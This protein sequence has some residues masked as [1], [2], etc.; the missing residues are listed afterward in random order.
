MNSSKK[1]DF[2]KNSICY[3][4]ANAVIVLAAIVVISIWGFNYQTSVTG[5]KLLLSS[6]LSIIISLLLVF[7]YVGLRYDF[8]KA[9]SIVLTV[10]HNALLSTALI[11]IIRV[12]VTE[13]IVMGYILLVGLSTA[14]TLILTEK[15]KDVNLKKVDYNEIIK[16]TMASSIKQ[17]VILSAVVV[18]VL[19]LCLITL[20][21]NM[22]N[23]IRILLV[24]VFVLIYSSLTIILPSW[25]YFSSKIK[26]VKKAK[27][28]NNVENQKVVKAAVI[29]GEEVGSATINN[30]ETEE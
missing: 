22:F 19:L 17:I 7:L 24:M 4:I 8:A 9:F 28:D 18:I 6:T 26:K 20:S 21:S 14:Y 10:V 2:Y 12:P 5:G 11:A 1:Y 23:L 25:C 16:N 13:S 30:D 27:V 29:D 15:L 3:L